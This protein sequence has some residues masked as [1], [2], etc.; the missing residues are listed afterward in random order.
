MAVEV[1]ALTPLLEAIQRPISE[2]NPVGEDI[3][4]DDDFLALKDEIDQLSSVNPVG[5]DYVQIGETCQMLLGQK[6]KDLRVSTYL[7][8]A[9][10]RTEGF[11]GILE[12]LRAQ[13]VLVEG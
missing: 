2:A 1:D 7:A 11:R 10:A 8:M 3:T 4:Y 13:E 12:G 5:V 6:A 9:L